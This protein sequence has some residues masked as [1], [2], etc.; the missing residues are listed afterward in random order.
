M[1]HQWHAVIVYRLDDEQA[2]KLY[3]GPPGPPI[4][5]RGAAPID[6]SRATL[7]A[8]MIDQEMSGVGCM[9]CEKSWHAGRH[10]DCPG[11]PVGYQNDGTPIYAAGARS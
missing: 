3:A 2:A 8:D 10:T 1:R 4:E 11:E 9:V 7:K 5:F 6:P